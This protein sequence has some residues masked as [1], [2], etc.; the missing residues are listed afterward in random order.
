VNQ[1]HMLC[2]NFAIRTFVVGVG[3]VPISLLAKETLMNSRF[4]SLEDSNFAKAAEG[5]WTHINDAMSHDERLRE[6]V[7]DLAMYMLAAASQRPS[8]AGNTNGRSGLEASTFVMP[9]MTRPDGLDTQEQV[10]A[11]SVVADLSSEATRKETTSDHT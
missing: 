3:F 9:P 10:D 6:Y 8:S 11:Q 1:R 5:I 4:P 2:R 7:H